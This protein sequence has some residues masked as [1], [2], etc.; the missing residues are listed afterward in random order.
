MS[1]PKVDGCSK[2]A[3]TR[4]PSVS[5]GILAIS[6]SNYVGG[7]LRAFTRLRFAMY[8]IRSHKSVQKCPT[9]ACLTMFH[10]IDS[11]VRLHPETA[12]NEDKQRAT[13]RIKSDPTNTAFNLF[14]LLAAGLRKPIFCRLMSRPKPRSLC[15]NFKATCDAHASGKMSFSPLTHPNGSFL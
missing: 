12:V 6:L 13:L 7:Q 9:S 2:A 15:Q 11:E 5:S 1:I 3:L 4:K 14:R 10:S 8:M